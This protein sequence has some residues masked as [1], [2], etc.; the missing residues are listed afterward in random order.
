MHPYFSIFG[1][2]IPS[3]GEIIVLG[4][5][6]SNA[7]AYLYKRKTLNFDDLILI[8]AYALLGA[9]LGGKL[10]YVLV[11]FEN[12]DFEKLSDLNYLKSLITS[13]FVFLGGL[14]GA[15]L[16]EVLGCKL[17][18]IKLQ[19]YL[20]LLAVFVPLV[21]A[22]GRL[23][24]FMAGCC[25]GVPCNGVLSVTYHQSAIAPNDTP[26]LAIQLIEA[27][28]LIMISMT[29]YVLNRYQNFR[30][31]AFAYYLI[32][33]SI[34]RIAI[35]NYRYDDGQRGIYF[36]LSTSQWLSILIIMVTIVYL[37]KS[38]RYPLRKVR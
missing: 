1:Y 5:I 30:V 13:G 24:C 19:E 36:Y 18:K 17:H 28:V 33:Y 4:V 2:S 34:A 22:F 3:Y 20:P 32:M 37:I 21:H 29:I 14:L 35:E 16:T 15:M 23:G 9:I 10:F 31:H 27:F 38:Y 25:Y 8:E 7:L 26:L 12:L 11:N 6:V